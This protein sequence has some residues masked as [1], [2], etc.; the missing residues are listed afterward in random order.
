[1]PTPALA[2]ALA[3]EWRAVEDDI[4]PAD[5]PVT[6]SVNAAIDKVIPQFDEVARLIASY[7][8]TD[9]LCYRAQAPEALVRR[10]AAGWDPLLDWADARFGARLSVACGVMPV[11][12]SDAALDRLRA[13]VTLATP[14]QLAALHDLVGLSGS[15]VLGLAVADGRLDADTGWAL[16]RIDETFQAEQWGR[17]DEAEAAAAFKRDEF[18]HAARFHALSTGAI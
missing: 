9:L 1:M 7:G 5:M 11:G 16:S 2:E 6:R 8:G 12:Q 15:L 4:R 13:R 3:E 10:Q 14:F 18:R 17:D